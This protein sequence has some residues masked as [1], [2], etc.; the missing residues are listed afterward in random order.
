M[1]APIQLSLLGANHRTAPLEL[2]EKLTLDE[3]R[4]DD[5]FQRLANVRGLAEVAI[6]STC[7]RVE[8]YGVARDSNAW[9][10]AEKHYC[11]VTGVE[12]VELPRF[13]LTHNGL[14]AARHLMEVSAGLDSQLVG[15][16][17]ILGQV[18]QA[19][20]LAIQHGTA[21]P[22]LH[23]LFQKSFQAAK[24]VRTHTGIGIGQVS[25]GNIAADLARRI[26]GDLNQSSVMV[27]GSGKV[28]ADVAK[29]LRNRGAKAL[30]VTSRTEERAARLA[31][32]IE[33]QM[34]PFSEWTQQLHQCDVT[35][36]CTA[37]PSMILT[38]KQ[39]AEAIARRP[40]RPLFFIDLAMPRDVESSAAKLPNV[41]LYT[42]DDL[43]G[44]ANENMKGRAAEI[45]ACRSALKERAARLWEELQSGNQPQSQAMG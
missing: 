33:G 39:I 27:V 13:G 42:F 8:M 6:L 5:L 17:E 3:A 26:F 19:Y 16:T 34:L 21:G 12:P 35:I 24:W 2:R 32:A 38:K 30:Y 36:L 7:N 23:R 10:E 4:R 40:G 41:F 14:D 25:L 43:A 22:V 20:K 1:T 18:K 28:G 45:D 44:I 15:E 37:A 11:E 9:H 29:A 31:E